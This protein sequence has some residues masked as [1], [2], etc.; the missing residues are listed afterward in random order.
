MLAKEGAC[1]NVSADNEEELD[2]AVPVAEDAREERGWI[3]TAWPM[4]LTSWPRIWK[5]STETIATK[6]RPSI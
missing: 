4:R 2:T 3:A 1:E 5:S 6:R